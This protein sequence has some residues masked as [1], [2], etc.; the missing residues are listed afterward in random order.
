MT[1]IAKN[2]KALRKQH[3]L[4]QDQ[5]AQKLGIK[6]SSIGAYEEGRAEP[7]I[8][9]LSNIARSFDVSIDR[10][11]Y[12]DL[13]V[14]MGLNPLTGQKQKSNSQIAGVPLKVLAITVDKSDNENIEFIPQKAAA[15]YL[16]G[17][18]DP[19]FL[20]DLPKFNLPN[21]STGTYRAFEI[22]GDS[23]QPINSGSIIVGRYL[24]SPSDLKEGERY[25]VV[26]ANEGIVF[27]RVFN[28]GDSIKLISDNPN[29]SPYSVKKEDV[30]EIWQSHSMITSNLPEP[31]NDNIVRIEKSITGI[32]K[33]I[34][35]IKI[36]LD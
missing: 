11:V 31:G 16:N 25:I 18:S 8:S 14:E 26:S 17:Y 2:I 28:D 10:L 32:A 35:Q 36:K 5:F 12:E 4:T 19:Q 13:E 20:K 9:N 22:S 21:L 27:K 1:L 23:M 34:H 30:L 29:F 24:D 15:G 6:R 33:D 3:N 7:P